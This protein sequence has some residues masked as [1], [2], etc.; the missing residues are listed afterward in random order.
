MGDTGQLIDTYA[1]ALQHDLVQLP[2][3]TRRLGVVRQPMPWL[4][5]VIDENIAPLGPPQ[6]LLTDM[7]SRQERLMARGLD[8]VVAHNR[9]MTD[10]DYDR[11]YRRHLDR[12]DAARAA[13]DRIRSTLSEGTDVALVCFENTEE[14]RCHR[15]Y[16]RSRIARETTSARAE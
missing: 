5:G 7:K 6:P 13:I 15:T 9:A 8:E 4:H 3:G 14:K 10:V 1:A 2:S 16:L 11:R 12:S